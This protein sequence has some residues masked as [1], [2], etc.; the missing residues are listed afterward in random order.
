M[1]IFKN[2]KGLASGILVI[3]IV[4]FISA[5][6]SIIS[7][8]MAKEFTD[9]LN[10]ISNETVS[11]YTKDLIVENTGF[12][13]WG[14][15]IFIMLFIVL[16]ITYLISSMTLE[17]QQPLFF[18]LFCFVLI[19]TTILAMWLSNSWTYILQDSALATAA[20]NL[21]FTDYFMRYLP[22]ITFIIGICG[23]VI[24]YAR[25]QTEF[26]E[27]AGGQTGGIE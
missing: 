15:K 14:D 10:N 16:L 27:G 9:T 3:L 7:L 21:K 12:M 5:F 4:M 8:V 20:Q 25:S 1:K 23:A 13:F 2:K 26:T 6:M 24:F 18:V 17:V 11:Q 19:L 22:I